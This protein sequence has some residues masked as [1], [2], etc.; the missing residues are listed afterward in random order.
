MLLLHSCS[1]RK[2]YQRLQQSDSCDAGV[3]MQMA[4]WFWPGGEQQFGLVYSPKLIWRC[5]LTPLLL[6]SVSYPSLHTAPPHLQTH[7]IA[8]FL[9]FVPVAEEH[10]PCWSS[11]MFSHLSI[12]WTFFLTVVSSCISLTV[13]SQILDRKQL[14]VFLFIVKL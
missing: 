2:K 8:L 13:W 4:A 1:R 11:I 12:V 10:A 9:Y 14:P 6:P 5:S 3:K 7:A